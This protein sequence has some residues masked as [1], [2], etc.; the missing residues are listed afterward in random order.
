[1]AQMFENG[2]SFNQDIWDTSNVT[3]MQ[4]MFEKATFNQD[5]WKLDTSNVTI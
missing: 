1:M 2:T 4:N 3:N 5:I